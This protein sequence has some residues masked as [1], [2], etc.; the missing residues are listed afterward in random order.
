MDQITGIEI[1]AITQNKQSFRFN[2]LSVSLPEAI[3]QAGGKLTYSSITNC[4]R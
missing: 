3:Y 1:R 4:F 2:D